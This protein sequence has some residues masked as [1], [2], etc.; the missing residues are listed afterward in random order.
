MKPGAMAKITSWPAELLKS[1]LLSKAAYHVPI[2]VGA[3]PFDLRIS[4]GFSFIPAFTSKNSV[5]EGSKLIKY[6]GS[7][8][9]IL[10]GW[11]DQS[12]R[13]Y[14]CPGERRRSTITGW[15][16]PVQW[17]LPRL[18][19][20]P[21]WSGHGLAA[22]DLA[23]R[24]LSQF[25]CFLWHCHQRHDQSDSMPNQ[26]HG[27]QRERRIRLLVTKH[28]RHLAGTGYGSNFVR[29]ALAEDHK[30]SGRRGY[31]CVPAELRQP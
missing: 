28:L 23:R 22:G 31:S 25:R 10:F 27:I 1:G 2:L 14:R 20:R 13:L 29:L 8:G 9:F 26:H 7:G 16:P 18:R 19:R 12:I 3:V 11:S 4:L 30:V 6:S 24:R 21:G 5:V 15:W 17:A